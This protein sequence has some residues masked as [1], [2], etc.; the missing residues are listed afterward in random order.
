MEKDP[1]CYY[2]YLTD[3]IFHHQIP[4]NPKS[5]HRTVEKSF[6]SNKS[7][8]LYGHQAPTFKFENGKVEFMLPLPPD[9]QEQ[10]KNAQAAGKSIV[11]VMPEEG[12]P[13][14]LGKDLMEK[15]KADMNRVKR[16]N[17]R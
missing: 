10:I 15:V 6:R 2:I 16:M 12:V 7:G 9:M 3:F 13:I 5:W 14:Y 1:N 11:L 17:E 4:V 8:R